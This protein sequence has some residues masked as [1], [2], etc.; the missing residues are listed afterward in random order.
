MPLVQYRIV[1]GHT[2]TSEGVDHIG[3]QGVGGDDYCRVRA[4]DGV[5]EYLHVYDMNT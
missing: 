3:D 4:D 2:F 5:L 1:P